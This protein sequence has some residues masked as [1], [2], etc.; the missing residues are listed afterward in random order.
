MKKLT[1]SILT[2][3][4]E[5]TDVS[6]FDISSTSP[7]MKV[8]CDIAGIS[9]EEVRAVLDGKF[10]EVEN[11]EEED[12]SFDEDDWDG[13]EYTDEDTEDWSSEDFDEY[14][15]RYHYYWTVSENY[16]HSGFYDTK[17][18]AV[19]SAMKVLSYRGCD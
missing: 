1:E 9:P 7:F 5:S 19:K 16:A 6:S 11:T 13:A 14:E 4:N 2:N 15:G 10:D 18:K 12:D 8:I 17:D 3:L